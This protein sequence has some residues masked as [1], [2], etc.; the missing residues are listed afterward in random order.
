M[1]ALVFGRFETGYGILRSLKELNADLY[2]IDYKADV[3]FNSKYGKKLTCPA[4]FEDEALVNWLEAE[5]KD[6]GEAKVFIS[7]DDFLDFF[8]R[9]SKELSFLDLEIPDA[10]LLDALQNKFFQ[11]EVCVQNDINAPSTFILNDN[12]EIE[13]LPYPLFLK[14]LEVNSWRK[15]YGGSL[16]GFVIQN[17]E[18]LKIWMEDHPYK[19]VETIVQSLIIGPDENHF[20]YCAYRNRKGEIKAEFMLQKLIQFPIG[21]GI[22]AATKSVYDEQ[23]LSQGRRL[24]ES[25]NYLG[26][27]SAE[28]KLDERD[29]KLKLIELNPR[30]WQQNFQATACGVNFPMRQYLDSSVSNESDDSIYEIG[31]IWMNRLIVARALVHYLKKGWPHFIERYQLLR[32]GPKVYSHFNTEDRAPY[33]KEAQNGIVFFKLPFVLLRDFLK[34]KR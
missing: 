9:N 30:Y 33:R 14:G 1:K 28:F 26:V 5:F 12:L 22:G 21:F 6:G 11:Y 29:G 20:K 23:L 15:H 10:T 2:S 4:P 31:T 32:K 3:A 27:G 19:E 16:K 24:F 17:S 13:S 7:S 8:N 34:A 18:E 25:I